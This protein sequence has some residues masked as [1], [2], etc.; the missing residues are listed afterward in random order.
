MDLY[1]FWSK[2]WEGERRCPIFHFYLIFP[3]YLHYFKKT[4]VCW[5]F[6][7]FEAKNI[8]SFIIIN[9]NWLPQRRT[10][11]HPRAVVRRVHGGGA[12]LL[13][14]GKGRPNKGT[15]KNMPTFTV[16]N[17]N[18]ITYFVSVSYYFFL[19]IVAADIGL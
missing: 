11:A 19:N 16:H 4:N 5:H 1:Y 18:T 13:Q 2:V 12:L 7:I 17:S 9:N 15:R 14:E 6:L 3:P 10:D 8:I